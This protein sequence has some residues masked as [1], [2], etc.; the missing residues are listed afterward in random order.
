MAIDYTKVLESMNKSII[1]VGRGAKSA[2]IF[3]EKT[4]FSPVIGGI[5]SY[6]SKNKITK[7]TA[8]IIA[9]GIENLMACTILLSNAGIDKILVE[10]PA[11]LSVDELLEHEKLLNNCEKSLFV[12]YNRRFY[13]SVIE[14]EKLIFE[15]CGLQSMHF[16]F[17]EWAHEIKLLKKA[18]GV[19]KNWFFANSTHVVDL[20]FFIAGHPKVLK[21][22]SKS[23]KLNWHNKTNFVGSGET[24]KGVLFS[25]ISN[26]ESAGRW[27]LELLTQ[28]RRIY[29]KPMENLYIQQKGSINVNKHEFD[30]SLDEKF[31]PGLYLQVKDFLSETSDRLVT[32]QEHIKNSKKVFSIINNKV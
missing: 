13:A 21:S 16:E 30:S 19:K 24:E 29:L 9:T 32:I 12:A 20:A 8:A 26:W 5:E 22:F 27:G 6:L 17:T 25:Y 14:A 11:A 23:G 3:Q 31:K 28:N 7:G 10:K 4:G 2:K 18:K 1:V 15:D